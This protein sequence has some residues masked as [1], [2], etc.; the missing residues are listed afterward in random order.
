VVDADVVAVRLVVAVDDFPGVRQRL[1][2]RGLLGFGGFEQGGEVAAR[3][4][5]GV[6]ERNGEAVAVD[7]GKFVLGEDADGVEVAE[8]AGFGGGHGRSR[9]GGAILLFDGH[10]PRPWRH[11]ARE[12][13]T[14]DLST[15]SG[16][17][18]IIVKKNPGF[19]MSQAKFRKNS[20]RIRVARVVTKNQRGNI[21]VIKA[22]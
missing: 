18:M 22:G 7:D 3:D 5:D 2:Q 17:F 21:A 8:G 1:Q 20:V 15:K 10:L 14:A 19:S 11:E 13:S 16:T 9:E 4:D 6:A 12:W